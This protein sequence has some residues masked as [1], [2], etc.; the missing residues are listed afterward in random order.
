VSGARCR[1]SDRMTVNSYRDLRVWQKAMDLVVTS[2][3][4]AS[5]FHKVNCTDWSVRSKERRFQ[6]PP[7]SRKATVVN[8]LATMFTICRWPTAR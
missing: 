8:I 5:S 7:T 2:Y 1:D 4:V 6:F 3:E